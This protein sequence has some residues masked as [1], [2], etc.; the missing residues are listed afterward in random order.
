VYKHILVPTDGSR[1]SASAVKTAT[2]LASSLSARVTA[3]HVMA[4]YIGPTYGE[5]AGPIPS[6]AAED[7]RKRV[8]KLAKA[9]LKKACEEAQA[10]RVACATSSVTSDRPW[11]AIV[12]AARNRKC[13]LIVMASHGRRGLSGLIFGSETH[14]VVTHTKTPVLVCR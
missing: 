5:G 9:A 13:D 10:S 3:F 8:R 7:H 11:L 1:L 4:P 14:K 6:L 2:R 12:D